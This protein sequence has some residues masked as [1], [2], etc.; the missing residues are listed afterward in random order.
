MLE[1]EGL[2][3][4][5][6]EWQQAE[7]THR[8]ECDR[9]HWRF[10][11]G[12]DSIHN[13]DAIELLGKITGKSS[14]QRVHCRMGTLSMETL[15]V[16]FAKIRRHVSFCIIVTVLFLPFTRNVDILYGRKETDDIYLP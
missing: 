5:W 6:E 1:G 12:D 7:V 2:A 11:W 8:Q 14:R 4:T 10:D 9:F 15:S 13:Q 3:E 16:F